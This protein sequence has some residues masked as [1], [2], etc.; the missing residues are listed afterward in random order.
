[1]PVYTRSNHP[2]DPMPSTL[3]WL[4]H[5]YEARERSLRTLSLFSERESRDE[6]GLGG[7]RDSFADQLFPGTSTIQT[8]V[9][10]ML[11]VPW[12]YQQLE[13]QRVQFPAIVD[14]ARKLELDL[15]LPLHEGG[16]TKGVFGG[17]VGT[18][19]KRLPSSVYWAGLGSWRIL[20]FRGSQDQYH[21]TLAAVYAVRG[22]S[23][24]RK[25]DEVE[26][27]PRSV[28]WHRRLP[29][30]PG[31]LFESTTFDLTFDEADFLKDRIAANHND[32]LLAHLTLYSGPADVRYP[33]EHPD[34]AGFTKRQQELLAH[35]RNFSEVM[36]G[37]A[38]TYN[39]LLAELAKREEL[40]DQR[41]SDYQRWAES[42]DRARLRSWSMDRMWELVLDH[43][44]NI[45][46]PTRSFVQKWVGLAAALAPSLLD[47]KG[48]RGLV[49]DRE[50]KLKGARSRFTNARAR[51]QWSGE[52]GLG[53]MNF[54][55]GTANSFLTD[56]R[57]GLARV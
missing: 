8:R 11:F 16:E 26:P 41:R 44:Y 49:E 47:H 12:I 31:D 38:I 35:A 18:R 48:A 24:D 51:D 34:Q 23:R 40:A 15:I 46:W 30:P 20:Q 22:R 37:A 27:D 3:T 42:L 55:W 52:A 17:V 33:W 50:R 13:Q 9:R 29:P 1:M 43:G 56:L 28:T 36:H 45:S 57:D 7:I 14:R 4:D 2:K 25:G 5:D 19:L 32:S 54:R 10:Y 53:R 6:L 39:V 21:R